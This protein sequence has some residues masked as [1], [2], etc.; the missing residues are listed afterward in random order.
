VLAVSRGLVVVGGVER[1]D[2]GGH[3]AHRIVG[4]VRI[5]HISD[6][7]LPRL[8]G[9][10]MQVQHL[11]AQ[12]VAVGH[13]VEILTATPRARHDRTALDLVDAVPVNRVT[14]DLPFELPVHLRVGRHVSRI[15]EQRRFDVVHLHVGLV[16]PFAY[17]AL[18]AVVRCAVPA[19]ATVHSLWGPTTA[20][21]GATDR[22]VHWSSRPVA[23][24]AVS[25]VA[26]AHVQRAARRDVQVDVLPNGIDPEEWRVLPQ[27]R[28]TDDVR[29]VAVM[30]LAPRKRPLPLMRMLREVRSLLPAGMRLHARV[31]G[32]GP[33]L[34]AM[35]RFRH[36]HRMTGWVD[37][38]GR[39]SHRAIRDLYGRADL[40]V[41][42]ANL[43]SF[44]IAA[45]E[46][47]TAGIPVVAKTATGIASFV[48]DGVQGLLVSSDAGM[49]DA[50]VR[51]AGD[52][53][54]RERIAAANRA[55]P[56]ESTWPDVLLRC[57]ALY[58]RAGAGTT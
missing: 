3:A 8:G 1:H 54:L 46:A 26:A 4:Q 38:P 16:S 39:L 28:Q 33:L 48:R 9:I 21:F 56:P 23:I 20:L 32:D 41:A 57:D 35:H 31:I 13:D 18:P 43:E 53:A 11:A 22:L 30:R 47:R 51:L 42:P 24:S 19:A 29:V 27:A 36:R 37:L 15:L 55:A 12:Q 7:Y 40:F 6:C 2:R 14:H 34:P 17:G 50:I 58:A 10:E 49:V 45:L 5:L 25:A 44:G 52:P